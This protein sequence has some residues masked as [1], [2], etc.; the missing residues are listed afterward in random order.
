M[1]RRSPS[2]T[3]GVSL[4]LAWGLCTTAF[5]APKSEL[6]ERWTAHV[7]ASTETIDHTAFGDILARYVKPRPDGVN[8]FDY[9]GFSDADR[10]LLAR[11]LSALSGVPISQYARP[12]QRAFW[13]NLYN[14]LTIQVVL[15]HYPVASIRKISISPGF[16][17][18]GPWAKELVQVESE[19]LTLDD[20][21]HRILRPIWKDPRIHY[22]VN[23]AA[24]GCPNLE[25]TAFTADN[26]EAMLDAGARAYVNHP[27]GARV[28]NGR[29]QTSSI[30]RWFKEDFGDNDAGVI[31]H[32]SRY[33][34]PDLK[35]ALA[36]V[37]RI[38]DHEYD[39]SLNDGTLV[40]KSR[41]ARMQA[42]SETTR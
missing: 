27:R 7:A 33:S 9:G 35:L 24:I 11:Y 28:S 25:R 12:E 3:L 21:E 20:I 15:D 23:C 8:R 19:A 2:A 4:L 22:A 1:C 30:Y 5:A 26:T 34:Q 38:A 17:S 16:F 32:L 31:Q 18:A 37:S 14:A 10:R 42:G 41:A 13:I 6:W 36:G 39:W 29:L 40:I